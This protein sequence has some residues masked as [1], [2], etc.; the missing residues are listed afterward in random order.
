[1]WEVFQRWS[2]DGSA[3]ENL[4]QFKKFRKSKE[5]GGGGINLL[6]WFSS[7]VNT[8]WKGESGNP[9]KKDS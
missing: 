2:L 5:R 4:S 8:P 9:V 6:K 1:M 7:V 3:G